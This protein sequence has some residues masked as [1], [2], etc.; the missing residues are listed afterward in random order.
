M[1]WMIPMWFASCNILDSECMSI[2]AIAVRKNRNVS[3]MTNMAN[4]SLATQYLDMF[5]ERIIRSWTRNVYR[6]FEST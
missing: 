2:H 5:S 6:R 4:V 1:H 3:I